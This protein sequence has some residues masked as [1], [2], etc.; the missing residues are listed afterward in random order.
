MTISLYCVC[1]S[2]TKSSYTVLLLLRVAIVC[3]VRVPQVRALRERQLPQADPLPDLDTGRDAEPDAPRGGLRAG[4]EEQ[5][6]RPALRRGLHPQWRVGRD[7]GLVFPI[8]PVVPAVPVHTVPAAR[9]WESHES[10]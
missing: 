3:R 1:A 9:A 8:R 6:L 2:L 7:A 4:E 10:E 5:P